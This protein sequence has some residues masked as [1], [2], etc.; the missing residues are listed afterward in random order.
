MK[1]EERSSARLDGVRS[2]S[3]RSTP[4]AREVGQASEREIR[5]VREVLL[6]EP[7]WTEDRNRKLASTAQCPH[8]SFSNT[9]EVQQGLLATFE[10]RRH[11]LC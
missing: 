3:G 7:F 6:T 8:K 1:R 2:R 10:S 11:D 9:A 5:E 4:H